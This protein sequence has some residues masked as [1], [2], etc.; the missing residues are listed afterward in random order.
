MKRSEMVNILYECI[1]DTSGLSDT[2][3]TTAISVVCRGV[4]E[5]LLKR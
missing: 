5:W 4:V 1:L 3:D 2:L